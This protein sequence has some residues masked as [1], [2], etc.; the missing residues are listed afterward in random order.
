MSMLR[1]KETQVTNRKKYKV[2]GFSFLSEL[3]CAP[4]AVPPTHHHTHTHIHSQVANY[5][6]S[7]WE[8][9]GGLLPSW[10]RTCLINPVLQEVEGC[11]FFLFRSLH[12]SGPVM[13]KV[14]MAQRTGQH[15]AAV[16][17]QE[18]NINRWNEL[19]KSLSDLPLESSWAK[20][21]HLMTL[22]MQLDGCCGNCFTFWPSGAT[23]RF[24]RSVL[25]ETNHLNVVLTDWKKKNLY[26]CALIPPTWKRVRKPAWVDM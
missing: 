10:Q 4:V 6:S 16:L 15:Y 17:W 26:L 13:G 9:A 20:N 14:W 24:K 8:Y 21:T 23:W 1:K 12:E 22:N 3:L 11:N 5:C 7:E 2:N 19:A 18:G 25:V